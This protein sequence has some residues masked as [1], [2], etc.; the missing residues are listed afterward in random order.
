MSK[1]IVSKLQR[2]IERIKEKCITQEPS[3]I[4]FEVLP[5]VSFHF[6]FWC[7][8]LF[9]NYKSYHLEPSMTDRTHCGEEQFTKIIAVPHLFLE[10]F[11]FDIFMPPYRKIGGIL[12][13]RCPSVCPSIC[14]SAQT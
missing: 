13:Y 6:Q 5:F 14:L 4:L 9:P 8:T 1:A 2:L 10:L 3:A 11:P 7:G 12:F